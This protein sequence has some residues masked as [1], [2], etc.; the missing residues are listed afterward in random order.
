MLV[1]L[2]TESGH[3]FWYESLVTIR[4]KEYALNEM[5]PEQ[6]EYIAATLNVNGLNAAFAGE[7]VYSAKLPPAREVFRDILEGG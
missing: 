5:T 1:E 7:R 3:K 4:G 2:T 6:Q